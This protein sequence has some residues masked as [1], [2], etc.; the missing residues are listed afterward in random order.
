MDEFFKYADGARVTGDEG[1]ASLYEVFSG[2]KISLKDA[3]PLT[4]IR[5]GNDP[6]IICC[7]SDLYSLLDLEDDFK[8]W[9]GQCIALVD[10]GETGIE[11]HIFRFTAD[12]FG[13]TSEMYWFSAG[14]AKEIVM[15]WGKHNSSL[16]LSFYLADV[17]G[18]Y[19]QAIPHVAMP[20]SE[21][22]Y[23]ALKGIR[24]FVI[25]ALAIQLGCQLSKKFAEALGDF[26]N[27]SVS[28]HFGVQSTRELKN[29][30]FDLAWA[31]VEKCQEFF[32]VENYDP[33][34]NK[35]GYLKFVQCAEGFIVSHPAVKRNC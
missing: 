20:N 35:Q 19:G 13:T 28:A 33:S 6:V 27:D 8:T 15:Y 11:R 32:A 12:A 29:S 7:A 1:T 14:L 25:H 3:L 22:E 31:L 9:L 16:F 18:N 26:I 17:A 24:P 21:S 34:W 23:R 10:H 4:Q 2:K 5:V 30:D